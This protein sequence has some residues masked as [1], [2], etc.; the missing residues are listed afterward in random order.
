MFLPIRASSFILSLFILA[1]CGLLPPLGSKRLSKDAANVHSIA[2]EKW[3]ALPSISDS[4]G[5]GWL[6]D[7]DSATLKALVERAIT[8]NPNLK[9]AE[10]RV[11]QA[12]AQTVQAGAAM[13]PSISTSFIASRTQTPSDQRFAGLNFI[14]NRFRLPLNVSWEIDFWG[15]VADERGAAKSRRYAVEEDFH[16]ARLSL[17]ATTVRTAITLAEV[18]S[19]I[20]LAEQNVQARR[21]QLGIME[22]QMERGLDPDRAALDVS[23]S[24]ADL[25][26]AESTIQQR[27]AT[28]DQTRRALEVLLGGYPAGTERGLSTLPTLRRSFPA[29]LPSELLLRRPDLRAAERRLEAALRSESAAKKAFLPS[30][31]LTGESGRT[32]QDT[33]KLLVPEAA[34]W[35]IASNVTQSL[36]QGGRIMATAKETRA[37]Y[38]EQLQTYTNSALTAFREVETAL[39]GDGFLRD[40][41]AALTTAASEAERAE[42]LA[43][44]QYEKGLSE[45]LT[46]LDAR[47]RAFDARSSLI[48]V[49]AQ[50]LR[51]RADLHLALG[52]EF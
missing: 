29:G 5:T 49:Q 26:R 19:L 30:I 13:L 31:R 21:V 33:D 48:S 23:L 41:A 37:K 43:Q 8:A 32:S 44:G 28:A 1:S 2:P 39:A 15:R 42:K 12:Q 10:A 16:A 50:R 14:N 20:T 9:A 6:S 11:T 24:R 18:Q 3:A 45:V 47:Q 7:Y 46:L 4:A 25:A 52:G 40:Q 17:A 34:I 35:S 38:E 51:N 27:R 36:F 22:K